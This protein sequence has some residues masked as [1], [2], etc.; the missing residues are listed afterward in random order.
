V[1]RGS[2]ALQVL[3]AAS[4]EAPS[5]A[6][7]NPGASPSFVHV[8]DR[9]LATAKADRWQDALSMQLALA[10]A[11]AEDIP[12]PATRARP[13]I[14]SR[15]APT[16]RCAQASGG[17]RSRRSARAGAASSLAERAPGGTLCSRL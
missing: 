13:R 7:A 14:P 10:A 8:V 3:R 1:H 4:T 5:L 2:G 6:L 15:P 16:L 11:L 9:A 12:A 17:R